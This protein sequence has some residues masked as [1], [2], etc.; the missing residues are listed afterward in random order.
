MAIIKLP[1]CPQCG[2]PLS[3]SENGQEIQNMIQCQYCYS[4]LMLEANY[5]M[6]PLQIPF[7]SIL[8]IRNQTF[9]IKNVSQWQHEYGV[10]VEYLLEDENKDEHILI[11][12]DENVALVTKTNFNKIA[13]NRKLEW[14]SL[15]PNTQVVINDFEWLVTEKRKLSTFT[16][17]TYYFSYLTGTNAELLILIFSGLSE[18]SLLEMRQGVWLSSFEIKVNSRL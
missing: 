6:V 2:S 12:E 8:K 15:E 13:S 9:H 7:N 17:N 5:N 10:R 4:I 14:S 1:N 18:N 3:P 16:A 11:K